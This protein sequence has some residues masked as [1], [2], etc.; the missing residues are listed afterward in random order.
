MRLAIIKI[1]KAR[2]QMIFNEGTKSEIDNARAV[3]DELDCQLIDIIKNRQRI[4][5]MIQK[6]RLSEGGPRTVLAR[7]VMIL[8]RYRAA[9]G[10]A[11]TAIA[12]S[13]LDLCRGPSQVPADTLDE[14]PR[15]ICASK[16]NQREEFYLSRLPDSLRVMPIFPGGYSLLGFR[17][18]SPHVRAANTDE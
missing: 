8:G 7:E 15:S 18:A 4:S 2:G 16:V 14:L 3:I 12:A 1:M 9:I 5:Q 6:Q 17:W 11:G 10:P 13:I